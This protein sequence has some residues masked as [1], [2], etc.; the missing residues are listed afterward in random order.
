[1]LAKVTY[2]N[3]N[4][5]LKFPNNEE[6]NF[7]NKLY[8]FIIIDGFED[9]SS[10]YLKNENYSFLFSYNSVLI[11]Q[12]NIVDIKIEYHTTKQNDLSYDN[13]L[14]THHFIKYNKIFKINSDHNLILFDNRNQR[15]W[16]DEIDILL[17]NSLAFNKIG[18]MPIELK[19]EETLEF[20]QKLERIMKFMSSKAGFNASNEFMQND[21]DTYDDFIDWIETCVIFGL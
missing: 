19:F 18:Q 4:M 6:Y 14:K 12:T 11:N 7:N 8:P 5:K 3:R 10:Y 15:I 13:F 21:F 20:W 16:K 9:N 17:D 2:T 1:M